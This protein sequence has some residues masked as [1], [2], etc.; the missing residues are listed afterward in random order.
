MNSGESE[1]NSRSDQ[2]LEKIEILGISNEVY[3]DQR[4]VKVNFSVSSFLENP[5]ASLKLFNQENTLLTEVNIVNI[6]SSTNEITLHIPAGQNKPG[7]YRISLELF[8]L[9]EEEI[10]DSDHQVSLETIPLQSSSTS[11]TLL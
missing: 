7:D 8:S 5:N 3:P 6:F 4:R 2:E 9:S 10:P 1:A 11:F